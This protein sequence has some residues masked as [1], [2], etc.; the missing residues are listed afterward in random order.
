MSTAS[1]KLQHQPPVALFEKSFTALSIGL[2]GRLPQIT[3]GAFLSSALVFG[4]DLS[5]GKPPTLH[6]I[7]DSPLD[8]YSANLEATGLFWWNLDSWPAASS[9][10]CTALS[11]VCADSPSCWKMNPVGTWR[12]LWRNDNLVIISKQDKSV[13]Q[14]VT[15]TSSAVTW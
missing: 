3:W 12:L 7:R 6:S 2:C 14:N 11:A 8:L 4:F 1:S 9:A 10:R 15:V 13:Y 5:C